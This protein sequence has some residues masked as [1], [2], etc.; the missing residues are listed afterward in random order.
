MTARSASDAGGLGRMME[1]VNGVPVRWRSWSR[2]RR[3]PFSRARSGPITGGEK[4]QT[5]RGPRSIQEQL[6]IL[7][8]LEAA[9]ALEFECGGGALARR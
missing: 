7:A 1:M 3:R 5:L 2:H 9:F 6:V 8:E 4:G